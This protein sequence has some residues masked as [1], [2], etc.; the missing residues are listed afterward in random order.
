MIKT[1][2]RQ[3]KMEFVTIGQLV[4]QDHILRVVDK[5]TD[6]EFIR[7]KQ[8][9]FIVLIT[10]ARQLIPW[11]CSRCSLLVIYSG[12]EAKGNW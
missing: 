1:N 4:P 5:L 9:I 3:I 11:F 12:F 8:L 2:D 10:D 7:K 6:F